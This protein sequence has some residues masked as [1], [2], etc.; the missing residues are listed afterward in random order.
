MTVKRKPRKPQRIPHDDLRVDALAAMGWRRA[1]PTERQKLP[2]NYWTYNI[3]TGHTINR[4]VDRASNGSSRLILRP[5][6]RGY[7][8]VFF[9]HK[10]S[11]VTCKVVEQTLSMNLDMECPLALAG[12]LVLLG[13][14]DPILGVEIAVRD[15][16][17][18]AEPD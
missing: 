12:Y 10:E 13:D 15:R 3:G 5:N 8:D 17:T 9:S 4:L 6:K 11:T 7:W 14:G 16:D 18:R 2:R 1:K